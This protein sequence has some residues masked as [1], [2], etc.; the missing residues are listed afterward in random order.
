VK[1]RVVLTAA[2]IALVALSACGSDGDPGD[3]GDTGG[4]SE[5]TVA[6]TD[7]D[8]DIDTDTDTDVLSGAVIC[9]RLSV[10]SV[11][12]DTGLDVTRAV[13]DDSGTPNCAYEYNNDTGAVSN[14][15]VASMQP[16]DMGGL[17]GS[18]AYDF[19]VGINE[20]VAGDGAETQEVSA[21]DAAI[22]ISG[23]GVQLGVLQVGDQVLTLIIPGADVASDSVDQLIA[24][25][26]TTLG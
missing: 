21:G 14:L 15:T 19:V 3:T 25:M 7:T 5:A 11:A 12:A 8:T 23:S 26:A 16:A 22:R 2:T 13:P 1:T 6:A 20:A 4:S 17:T 18:E 10:D 24:T 9:E